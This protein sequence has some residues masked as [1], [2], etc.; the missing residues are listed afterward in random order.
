MLDLNKYIDREIRIKFVGGREVTGILK[1][2]DYLVSLVLDDAVEYL[3]D[4]LDPTVITDK[5]RKLGQVICKGQSVMT[6]C[7]TD[8]MEEIANPF[9]EPQAE[10]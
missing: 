2:W 4:P 7:P 10:L 3:R 1:G 5:T 6:L 9:I 8:G